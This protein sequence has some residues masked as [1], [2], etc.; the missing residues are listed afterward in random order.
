MASYMMIYRG[1]ATDMAD[2]S[3][4]EAAAVLGKWAAWMESVGNA[5]SDVGAPF[6]RGVSVVD[7]GSI[8]EALALTGYSIV[9][10]DSAEEAQALT[11]GHP[12]LSDGAG[13]FSIEVFELMPV[14]FQ[15]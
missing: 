12:Y 14:P 11:E 9:E 8:R 4:D 5:L 1:E 6:G 7:D 10:A 13:Q 15:D 3:E 2:M